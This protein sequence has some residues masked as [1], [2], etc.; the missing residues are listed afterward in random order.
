MQPKREVLKIYDPS[1][2]VLMDENESTGIKRPDAMKNKREIDRVL[3]RDLL[4][5]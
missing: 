4:L 5:D 1:G 3:L 2:K